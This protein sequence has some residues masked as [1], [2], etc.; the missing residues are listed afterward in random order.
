MG[1]LSNIFHKIF[2]GKKDAAPAATTAAAPAAPTQ[3]QAAPAPSAPAAAPA[4]PAAAPAA[5]A[6]PMQQVDVEQVLND[7]Q[8]SSGQ[9]LNWRTSIVDLLK[10]LGLD[11]SL[12]S[13]KELAAE[14]NYTGDTNDSAKMN[15]W[16]HRQ[17]MNKLAAN[18]GKVP[19]DLRD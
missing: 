14:L 8:K 2:P 18:G 1:I 10:L 5:A 7:M 16:L 9:Q 3:P 13:R 11:S 12:A 6:A 19:A 17:V 15:I 4:A